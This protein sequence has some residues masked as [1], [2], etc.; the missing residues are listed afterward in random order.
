MFPKVNRRVNRWRELPWRRSGRMAAPVL[1]VALALALA[2][3]VWAATQLAPIALS[4]DAEAPGPGDP[5][6]T[7][8]AA[9][10][11]VAA[12]NQI[13][14]T[15][16]V[17]NVDAP[18]AAHIHVAP[19]GEPGPVVVPLNTPTDGSAYGCADVPPDIL[20]AIAG[21]PSNYYVN[22]HN[23]AYPDGAVRGQLAP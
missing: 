15:L 21:N 3:P 6:G 17:S 7:G 11:L 23:E 2:V 5:D 8:N 16:W 1:A 12:E 13:C 18:T 10:T 22:V 20:N 14:Y 4:G 9:V 19:A